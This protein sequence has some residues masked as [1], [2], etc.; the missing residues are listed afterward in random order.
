MFKL[1]VG[2][3]DRMLRIVAGIGLIG[4]ALLGPDVS[5]KVAGWLGFPMLLTALF[6]FCPAY[7]LFGIS[8]RG[9]DDKTPGGSDAPADTEAYSPPFSA[10][11]PPAAPTS[12]GT[13]GSD[14][15]ARMDSADLTWLTLA[16]AVSLVVRNS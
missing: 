1:N 14:L 2:T 6:R 11:S 7:P 9:K 4:F 15:A 5:Y 8:T 10:S 13:P 12:I 3:T 16:A